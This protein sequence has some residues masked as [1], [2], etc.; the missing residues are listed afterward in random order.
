VD[1]GSDKGEAAARGKVIAWDGRRVLYDSVA[2]DA[3]YHNIDHQ[4]PALNENIEDNPISGSRRVRG[5][6]AFSLISNYN[7]L[8]HTQ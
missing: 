3:Y 7:H 5:P 6:K 2:V 4:V 8:C 1:A